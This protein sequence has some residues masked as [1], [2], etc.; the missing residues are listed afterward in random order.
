MRFFE[1]ITEAIGWLQ[2]VASPLI[3]GV[4]VGIVVYINYP[5]TTGLLIAI[6]FPLLGLTLGLIWAT[7]IW[8]KK[9]TVRFLSR[10]YA[11]PELDEKEEKT[12]PPTPSRG[13]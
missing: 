12:P 11:T 2:I 3:P 10:I 1:F 4:V 9:G 5:S 13:G 6:L 7:R 8:R